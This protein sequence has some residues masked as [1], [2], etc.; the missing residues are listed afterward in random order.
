MCVYF[1]RTSTGSFGELNRKNIYFCL[2][3]HTLSFLYFVRT[4]TGSIEFARTFISSVCTSHSLLFLS[5]KIL[6]H[7]MRRKEE[8]EE[9][10]VHNMF[11]CAPTAAAEFGFF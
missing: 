9:D 11:M 5:T 3:L 2:E 6:T 8:E 10:E 4:S 1:V 7:E